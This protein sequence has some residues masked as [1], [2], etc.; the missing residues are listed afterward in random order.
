MQDVNS[1]VGVKDI[2]LPLY[3]AKFWMKLLGVVMIIAGVAE[4]L[5]IIGIL[6]AWLPIWI[7]VLLFQAA[8]AAEAA[9]ANADAD[10]AVRAMD[11]LKVYFI[12]NGVLMLLMLVLFGAAILLGGAGMFMGM[13]GMHGLGGG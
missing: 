1:G 13:Q 12:I 6:F 3:N 7:G 5:T 10:A 8:G 4:A 2:M 11:K 9:Y